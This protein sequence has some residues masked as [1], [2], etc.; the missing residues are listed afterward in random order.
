[1]SQAPWLRSA[2]L[3]GLCMASSAVTAQVS[4]KG[5]WRGII[6]VLPN[7]PPV[8]L[9]LKVAGETATLSLREPLQCNVLGRFVLLDQAGSHYKFEPANGGYC[10]RLYPGEMVVKPTMDNKLL[11]TI[12]STSGP[13]LHAE[14]EHAP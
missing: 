13:A 10:M 3:M 7:R 11:I 4:P 8:A 12:P 14:L 9:V 6:D 2:L 1:M 5:N